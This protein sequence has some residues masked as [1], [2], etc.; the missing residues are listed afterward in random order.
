MSQFDAMLHFPREFYAGWKSIA[1]DPTLWDSNQRH[2]ILSFGDTVEVLK[3]SLPVMLSVEQKNACDSIALCRKELAAQVAVFAS[4]HILTSEITSECEVHETGLHFQV[5]PQ[6]SAAYSI[7]QAF[8]HADRR[9][10]AMTL[11]AGR[12]EGELSCAAT[13]CPV[14][15]FIHRPA[16]DGDSIP[17]VTEMKHILSLWKRTDPII[18]MDEIELDDAD[19]LTFDL[20]PQD[21][22]DVRESFE[23]PSDILRLDLHEANDGRIALTLSLEQVDPAT[24]GILNAIVDSCLMTQALLA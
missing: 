16:F 4:Y 8:G 3:D 18:D 23:D 12:R 15:I 9:L 24:G 19:F 20:G 1:S 17:E 7:G 21:V 22:A 5:G 11:M 14:K 10:Q 2:T 6:L 13:P